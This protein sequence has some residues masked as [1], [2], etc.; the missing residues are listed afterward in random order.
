MNPRAP[1]SRD[2]DWLEGEFR[3]EAPSK[4]LSRKGWEAE[5]LRRWSSSASHVPY[6][7]ALGDLQV[8]SSPGG[9]RRG[10]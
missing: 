9:I 4:S 1:G 7:G 2:V 6:T 10:L 3:Q 5:W 8:V